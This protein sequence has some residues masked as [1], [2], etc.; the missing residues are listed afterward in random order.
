[1]TPTTT[2]T[3]TA[4]PVEGA[5]R[6]AI[7]SRM[8]VR[9]FTGKAVERDIIQRLLD[10]AV[11]APN[12][13]RTLPWRFLV[14]DKPGLL[15]EKLA[16]LSY[17]AALGKTASADDAA[18]ARATAKKQEVFDTPVLIFAYSVP[19]RFEEE[20]KENYASVCCAVQNLMVAAVEEG[21][22]SGWSTGGL[23]THPR[24]RELIGADPSW[25][26][27]GLLYLGRP[28]PD[29]P[30]RAPRPGAADCTRWLSD[31]ATVRS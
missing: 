6:T 23:S 15:R 11:Q 1:M 16:E 26:L 12:H 21:L 7:R 22:A 27:V 4:T 30:A 18:Q 14:V 17:E 20:T 25:D 24:V 29:G 13:R 10:C 28:L 3:P 8:N 19:G 31:E 5:V 2:E 9:R